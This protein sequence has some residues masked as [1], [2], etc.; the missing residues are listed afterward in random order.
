MLDRG[1]NL[2]DVA[3]HFGYTAPD[4]VWQLAVKYGGCTLSKRQA[5]T[6]QPSLSQRVTARLAVTLR[7]RRHAGR[8]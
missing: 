5:L 8:R 7:G 3:E 4:W 2:Y 1:V 6:Q